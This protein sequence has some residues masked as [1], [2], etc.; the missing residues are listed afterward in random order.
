MEK[1][2]TANIQQRTLNI[3]LG[4]AKSITRRSSI[5][6]REARIC[7]VTFPLING[8]TVYT[9]DIRIEN[10]TGHETGKMRAVIFVFLSSR[11]TYY[12]TP[13]QLNRVDD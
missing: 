2:Q 9:D 7:C 8:H 1:K 10:K 6:E 11:L 5:A 12:L 13:V 3:E 4:D